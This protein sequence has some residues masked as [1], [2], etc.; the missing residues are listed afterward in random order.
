[1]NT[2]DTVEV[3]NY[4]MNNGI[5]IQRE[6]CRNIIQE[7][8]I[9]SDIFMRNVLKKAACTELILQIIMENKDLHILEQVIQMDYKNLQG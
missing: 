4:A 3:E 9:M 2:E 6:R 7:L 8:T 1:M 5:R